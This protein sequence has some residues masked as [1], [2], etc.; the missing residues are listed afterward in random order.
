MTAEN[1]REDRLAVLT[2]HKV[3]RRS[4]ERGIHELSSEKTDRSDLVLPLSWLHISRDCRSQDRRN[5]CFKCGV[6]G[7][8]K[9][10]CTS[11]AEYFLCKEMDGLTI[12]GTIRRD[13]P[14]VR[15]SEEH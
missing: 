10:D 13:P 5:I 1:R 15:R 7:D 12:R 2:L 6:V 11:E 8:G 14:S 4:L 9:S 3:E